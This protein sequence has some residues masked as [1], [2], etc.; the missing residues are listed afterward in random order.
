[1]LAKDYSILSDLAGSHPAEHIGTA[2]PGAKKKQEKWT[3]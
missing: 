3:I 2:E 1:M